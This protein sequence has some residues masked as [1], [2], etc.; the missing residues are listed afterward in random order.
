MPA[1]RCEFGR[2]RHGQ[3]SFIIQSGGDSDYCTTSVTVVV[4]M[5]EPLVAVTVMVYV[6]AAVPVGL[7]GSVIDA[8]PQP[9]MSSVQ[10]IRK[11]GAVRK[12]IPPRPAR[13]DF[14]AS[15]TVKPSKV[16]HMNVSG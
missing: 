5:A 7:G 1:C 4:R 11:A 3:R 10:S 16:S 8:D 2:A 6:P 9:A 12:R 14:S 13:L 15:A